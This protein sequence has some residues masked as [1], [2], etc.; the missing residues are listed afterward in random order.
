MP[1]S[2]DLPGIAGSSHVEVDKAYDRVVEEDEVVGT[3]IVVTNHGTG[4]DGRPA[5]HIVELADDPNGLTNLLV[6]EAPPLRR[7]HPGHVGEG[8]ASD[9]VLP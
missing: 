2:Q 3:R 4:G 9:L 6:W 1:C 8:V 7:R 5:S